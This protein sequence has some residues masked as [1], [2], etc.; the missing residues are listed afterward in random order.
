MTDIRKYIELLEN[1]SSEIY[2]THDW[3][4]AEG[5]YTETTDARF[6]NW[7]EN[8]HKIFDKDLLESLKERYDSVVFLNNINVEEEERGNGHGSELLEEFL[9][10]A[11]GHY[12]DA[13]I[14]LADTEE[15]QQEGFDLVAFY[16]GYDFEIVERYSFG[17]LM[18][19]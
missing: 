11:S 19:L 15:S 17:V 18:V 16:G 14:L 13:I 1:V 10:E 2:I 4:S 5:Y 9:E 8:R 7:F 6:T 3:G 12:P